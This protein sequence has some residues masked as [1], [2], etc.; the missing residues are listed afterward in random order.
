MERGTLKVVFDGCNQASALW[1]P[2]EDADRL[3]DETLAY[4]LR[5]ITLGLDGTQ[6]E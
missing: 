4:Q 2:A 6:C 5:R 3:G 1:T